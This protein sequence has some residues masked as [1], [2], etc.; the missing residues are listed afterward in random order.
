MKTLPVN[1]PMLDSPTC[2]LY[3]M[4]TP[5]K[6]MFLAKS[7][8]NCRILSTLASNGNP[9]SLMQSFDVPLV[10]TCWNWD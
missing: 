3:T 4:C 7:S 10:I 1:N 6:T 8:R 2:E 9:R 5:W